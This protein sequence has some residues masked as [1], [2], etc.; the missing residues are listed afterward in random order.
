MTFLVHGRRRYFH[1]IR[2]NAYLIVLLI[3]NALVWQHV[4]FSHDDYPV[5]HVSIRRWGRRI[6]AKLR[7]FRQTA[8]CS[9]FGFG[10][11]GGQG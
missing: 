2:M 9:F 11:M 6:F 5:G 4:P 8:P 10:C 3:A 1:V 7:P